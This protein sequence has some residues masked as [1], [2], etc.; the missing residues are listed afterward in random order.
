MSNTETLLLLT[1]ARFSDGFLIPY[2]FVNLNIYFLLDVCVCVS[3]STNVQYAFN[4]CN[5]DIQLSRMKCSI[6]SRLINSM[7]CFFFFIFH[8]SNHNSHEERNKS[9][10]LGKTKKNCFVFW[11]ASMWNN[12]NPN[13]FKINKKTNY[14]K[15]LTN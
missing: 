7:F 13:E 2:A 5:I 15:K 14:K 6:S 4:Q 11:C 12:A 9:F 3:C 1:F 10:F 8:I